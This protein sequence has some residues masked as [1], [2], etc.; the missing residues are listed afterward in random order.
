M[1]NKYLLLLLIQ[2]I[3]IT[4]YSQNSKSD[5]LEQLLNKHTQN[6]SLKV[7]LLTKLASEYIKKDTTKAL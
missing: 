7:N 1:K 4:L 2:I 3:T 5:S 6:D